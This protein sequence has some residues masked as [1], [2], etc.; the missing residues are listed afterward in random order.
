MPYV[1]ENVFSE[2]SECLC[3]DV[4][5]SWR[6]A[7]IIS[8]KNDENGHQEFYIHYDGFDKRWDRYV[9]VLK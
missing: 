3:V 2:G 7:T 6:S 1:S 9:S 8:I 4:F 5:G